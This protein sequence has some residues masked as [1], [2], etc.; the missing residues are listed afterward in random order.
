MAAGDSTAALTR[1]QR[2][3][4]RVRELRRAAGF[5]SQEALARVL[6]VS[7]FTVSRW[8]RGESKPDIDGLYRLAGALG[9]KAT[10]LLPDEAAA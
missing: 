2:F 7:L 5:D 10:D 4:K 3:G 6:H 1:D 8:E 9:V